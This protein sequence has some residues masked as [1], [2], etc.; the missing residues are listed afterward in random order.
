MGSSAT[1]KLVALRPQWTIDTV[2]TIDLP[3]AHGEEPVRDVLI[4][5]QAQR[6]FTCGEDGHVRL[7]GL[8]EVMQSSEAGSGVTGTGPQRHKVKREKKPQRFTPY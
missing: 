7:W 4:D 3:G 2:T 1:L 5:E 8:D 6:I